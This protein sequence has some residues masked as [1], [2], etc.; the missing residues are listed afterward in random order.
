M[1][2]AVSKMCHSPLSWYMGG[3][4]KKYIHRQIIQMDAMIKETERPDG[5]YDD[6]TLDI[7][8][9]ML[10]GHIMYSSAS[11]DLALGIYSS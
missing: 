11:Y 9:L 3:P 1:Y 2:A 7:S 10:Y 6:E 4:I 5:I 8:L